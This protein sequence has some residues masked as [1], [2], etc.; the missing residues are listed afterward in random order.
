MYEIGWKLVEN[1][2]QKYNKLIL[3]QQEV[4]AYDFEFLKGAIWYVVRI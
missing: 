3:T 2:D 4:E 1:R